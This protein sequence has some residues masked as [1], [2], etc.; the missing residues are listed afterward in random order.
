M[1]KLEIPI[2]SLINL[3]DTI[4]QQHSFIVLAPVIISDNIIQIMSKNILVIGL[5]ALQFSF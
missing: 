2:Q 1:V 3:L 5:Q 4:H